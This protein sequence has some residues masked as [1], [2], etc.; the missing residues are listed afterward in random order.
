[1]ANGTKQSKTVTLPQELHSIRFLNEYEVASLTGRAVQ[2][3]RNERF[4]KCGIRYSKVG[5]SIRYSLPDVLNFMEQ[6]RIQ[7]EEV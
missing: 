2:T 3:L 5:R 7:T 1:M 4:R 6:H